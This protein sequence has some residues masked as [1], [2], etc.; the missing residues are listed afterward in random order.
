MGLRHI[1]RQP[2]LCLRV[3]A[4]SPRNGH[5]SLA[6]SDSDRSTTHHAICLNGFR[7]LP[8]TVRSSIPSIVPY[9]IPYAQCSAFPSRPPPR[10]ILLHHF[11]VV[12]MDDTPSCVCFQRALRLRPQRLEMGR[13]TG[14]HLDSRC[15]VHSTN[16]C[17]GGTYVIPHPECDW[18]EMGS[19][20]TGRH[21]CDARALEHHGGLQRL[22][23]V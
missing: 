10:W 22:R 9:A 13:R 15:V 18:A 19:T 17:I 12:F 14:R 3:S 2:L 4:N 6:H 21:H 23:D 5:L 8:P 20:I 11:L 7:L 16:Y 1:R